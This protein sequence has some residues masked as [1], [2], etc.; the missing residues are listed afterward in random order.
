[1]WKGIGEDMSSSEFHVPA[2]FRDPIGDFRKHC[3]HLKAAERRDLTLL[4][5]PIY[6]YHWV[7]EEDYQEMI[8]LVDGLNFCFDYEITTAQI[9][10]VE[11]RL[12]R[13]IQYYARQYYGKCWERLST[14]LHVF[15]QVLHV[16]DSIRWAGSMY[17][18]CQWPMERVSRMIAS[19]VKSRVFTNRNITIT[20]V[21]NE[22]C[23]NLLY[24]IASVVAAS[25]GSEFED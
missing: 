7:P 10:V 18:Y 17:L 19:L 20:L 11:S 1:M 4:L 5:A 21:L 24:V 16:A 12:K 15:H 25:T 6:M 9:L 2:Q 13:F 23:N 14:C 22:Q 3:H 8:N